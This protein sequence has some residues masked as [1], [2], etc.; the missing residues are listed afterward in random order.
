MS[1]QGSLKR[2]ML[3]VEK[4]SKGRF[5]SFEGL[6]TFL[7]EQGFEVSQRTIERDLADIRNEFAIE[8]KYDRTRKGYYAEAENKLSIHSFL[9]FMELIHT[10]DLLS[11]SLQ[12]SRSALVHIQFESPGSFQGVKLLSP[13]LRAITDHLRIQFTH[14]SFETGQRKNFILSPYLLKQYQNRWYVIGKVEGREGFLTFGIDRMEDLELTCETFQPSTHEN[15]AKLFEHTIGLTYSVEDPI[16]IELSF[17]VKQ[18]RYLKTLPLHSSQR[19]IRDD[20]QGLLVQLLVVPNFEF[21]QRIWMLGASVT[22]REPAWLANEI[23]EDLRAG[24]LNYP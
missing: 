4:V 7:F 17:T 18:G 8:I 16:R 14:L 10:A 13:L 21:K 11:T 23:A 24:L 5:P 22:V 3:I 6:K 12:E 19:I 15:P 1:K 2:Y 20:E 9:N